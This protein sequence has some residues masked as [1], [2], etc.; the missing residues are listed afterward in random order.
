MDEKREEG[1]VKDR[2]RCSPELTMALA[3]SVTGMC[4]ITVNMLCNSQNRGVKLA[5]PSNRNREGT[6]SCD[7]CG[8]AATITKQKQ[9][10]K[11]GA[12]S[13]HTSRAHRGPSRHYNSG[14][15]KLQYTHSAVLR[16]GQTETF[17][18]E[19]QAHT[20]PKLSDRG[21][22]TE[23]QQLRSY[24]CHYQEKSKAT[25]ANWLHPDHPSRILCSCLEHPKQQSTAST[26]Q[27]LEAALGSHRPRAPLPTTFPHKG[28]AL[29]LRNLA[30][31]GMPTSP[32]NTGDFPW[33]S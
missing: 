21:A 20:V 32:E 26:I 14:G 13:P 16:T 17:L 30:K 3:V 19:Q 28:G 12:A 10:Y 8:L 23:V 6:Q 31:E 9:S 11:C 7:S 27:L 22:D 18:P 29:R 25:N 15:V 24:S 1:R 5:I 2:D 4:H 33:P